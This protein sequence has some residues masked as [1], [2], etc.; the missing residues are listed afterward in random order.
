PANRRRRAGLRFSYLAPENLIYQ[1]NGL[2]LQ[3]GSRSYGLSKYRIYDPELGIFLSRDFLN[4]PNKYRA[5]SN[6]PV[7]QVD[8]NGLASETT[9]SGTEQTVEKIVSKVTDFVDN[10]GLSVIDAIFFI[11]RSK[12]NKD[13]EGLFRDRNRTPQEVGVPGGIQEQDWGTPSEDTGQIGTNRSTWHFGSFRGYHGARAKYIL[14]SCCLCEYWIW[15]I[16]YDWRIRIPKV[17]N[18]KPIAFVQKHG[19]VL[20]PG[21]TAADQDLV[22]QHEL[23]HLDAYFTA[24]TEGWAKFGGRA[25]RRLKNVCG[26]GD[27]FIQQMTFSEPKDTCASLANDLQTEVN[28]WIKKRDKELSDAYHESIGDYNQWH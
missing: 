1:A 21:I 6:N 11:D 5:W 14:R 22:L 24:L 25:N 19:G 2:T 20:T 3:I 9:N 26:I 4:Y 17:G 15:K 23:A 10:P 18:M 7:G 16:P 8:K 13:P 28:D 12:E 27:R